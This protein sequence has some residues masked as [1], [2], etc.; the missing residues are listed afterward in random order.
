MEHGQPEK[1]SI[2]RGGVDL[3]SLGTAPPEE[4]R[5]ANEEQAKEIAAAEVKEHQTEQTEVVGADEGAERVLCHLILDPRIPANRLK[6]KGLTRDQIRDQIRE[7]LED[8]C[9][10]IGWWSDGEGPD[11]VVNKREDGVWH[12][13]AKLA[14]GRNAVSWSEFPRI[15]VDER[16]QDDVNKNRTTTRI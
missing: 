5:E 2:A 10:K 15:K 8:H 16:T 1:D 6:M 12:G 7:A 13:W 11:F 4:Q 3:S 14:A 9:R